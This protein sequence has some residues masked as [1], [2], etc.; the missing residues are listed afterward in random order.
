MTAH[1]ARTKPIRADA[2]RNR[3]RVLEAARECFGRDGVNAQIDDVAAA[4]GVGVGTVYRHFATKDV[5]L[6]AL[7]DDYFAAQNA[8]ARKAL[9][10][11]DPWTGFRDYM[12]SAVELLAENRAL[13]QVMSDRPEVM[14]E[15]AHAADRELGFFGTLDALIDRAKG[16][17]ALRADFELEDIPAVVCSLGS[18]QITKG[19]YANWRRLLEII[20]DGLRATGGSELPAVGTRLPRAH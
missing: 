14:G 4:A 17:G 9:E 8:L 18:L 13:A 7:A 10:A 19:A 5:L 11:G 16:A 15:A 12:R 3:E 20:L 2:R 6:E 1:A